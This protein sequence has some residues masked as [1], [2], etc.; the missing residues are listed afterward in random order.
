MIASA[1][2]II[3]SGGMMPHS[4]GWRRRRDERT[5]SG[6]SIGRVL[7]ALLREPAFARGIAVGRLAAE[8]QRIVGPRLAAETSPV[9]VDGGT[10]IVA[11]STGPWGAQAGFLAEEIKRQAN[12]ALG[13]E[14]VR[15][16][17]V[18]VRPDDGNPL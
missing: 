17:R 2:F 18:V 3:S 5:S 14:H 7:E 11:A 12:H 10:L 15:A 1:Y 6:E 16:V 4:K 13:G 9:S 8:W